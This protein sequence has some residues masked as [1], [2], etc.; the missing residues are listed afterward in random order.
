MTKERRLLDIY[1]CA[2]IAILFLVSTAN[3]AWVALFALALVA[4]GLFVFPAQRGRIV[5]VALIGAS[6]GLLI[7]ALVRIF[8]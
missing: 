4:A 2:A 7:A 5:T 8:G 6:S 1:T 3:A